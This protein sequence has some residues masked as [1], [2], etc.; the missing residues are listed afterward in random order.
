MKFSHLV[1][2]TNFIIEK[3]DIERVSDIKNISLD[4]E[5]NILKT[6]VASSLDKGSK[7]LPSTLLKSKS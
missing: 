6:A 4:Y 3:L 2:F 5:N 7:S 1:E